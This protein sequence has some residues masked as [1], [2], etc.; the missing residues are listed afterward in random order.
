MEVKPFD[1]ELEINQDLSKLK[2]KNKIFV[3]S[4]EPKLNYVF[5]KPDDVKKDPTDVGSI[6]RDQIDYGVVVKKG[7]DE[8]LDETKPLSYIGIKNPD[9]GEKWYREKYPELP[10]DFYG[11]I[12]RYT[13]GQPQ[14]KKSIKNEK[15]KYAKKKGKEKPPQGLSV[16]KGEFEVKFE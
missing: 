14:T 8:T 16:L 1:E 12:A 10:E 3:V 7:G 11:I 13:W 9:D 2:T 15:K 4:N 5:M 6:S